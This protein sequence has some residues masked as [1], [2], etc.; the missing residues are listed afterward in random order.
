MIPDRFF[1]PGSIALVGAA[2]TD[3]KLGGIVLKNLLR[4][5]GKVYP[6]NPKY[7]ELMGLKAYASVEALPD[8]VD[9]AVIMRP[10]PEVPDILHQF[11]NKTTCAIVV[12]SGFAEVGET[13]LQDEVKRVGRETGIRIVGPNCMGVC[14]PSKRLDTFFLTYERMKRPRK[15]NVAVVSQSGALLICLFEVIK[16]WNIGLSKAIGY[17]NAVDI[18]VSDIFEYLSQDRA[19]DVVISYIESVGD[20]R[21]F[22][23]S[24]KELSGKK[25]L[26]ILKSGKGLSGQVAAYS[27]TGRL[28]GKYEVF[29]SVLQQFGI[30]E[31]RDLD[32]LVDATKALSYQMPVKGNRVCILTNGGGAGVLAAD[33]CMRQGLEIARLPE[34]KI[35]RL[36][37]MFPHFYGINNP[38]DLT[39]QVQD[40]EY[41]Q[42]LEE[43][44]DDYDGFLIIAMAGVQGVSERLADLIKDF[45]VRTPKPLV[46][47]TTLNTVSMRLKS[48]LEKARIPVF[49]SPERA[50]RGLR[51]L[52]RQ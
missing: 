46:F 36:R 33:E 16:A 52:L 15:G 11:K 4:F 2:H 19:T 23:E 6:V 26:V 1:D 38:L 17:G 50:I 7:N 37:E 42:V 10:A 43:L 51:A 27:H 28:A 8:S 40:K 30:Q 5:K 35:K 41:L 49:P 31:A 14:N 48:L 3:I 34:D 29:H 18:D 39:A 24:A 13:G 20:G 32:E 25:S 22:V 21:R 9:L 45:Q 47:Y 12:S 44:H